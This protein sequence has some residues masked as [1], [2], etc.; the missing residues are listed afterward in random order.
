MVD[1]IIVVI[2]GSMCVGTY[3]VLFLKWI[4]KR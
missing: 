2:R 1:N 4:Y 3:L